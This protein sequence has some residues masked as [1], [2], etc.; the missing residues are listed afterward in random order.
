MPIAEDPFRHHNDRI[1]AS[2]RVNPV[3]VNTPR[4]FIAW[5]LTI[6]KIWTGTS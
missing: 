6:K 2:I 3:D 5:S 4:S 1:Q